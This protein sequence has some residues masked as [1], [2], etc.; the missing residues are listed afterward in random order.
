MI[1]LLLA[2]D[3]REPYLDKPQYDRTLDRLVRYCREEQDFRGHTGEK[4]WA[5]AAAHAADALDECAAS[6][7][8][9]PAACRMIWNGLSALMDG[10]RFVYQEEE[11]ERIATALWSMLSLE[12]VSVHDLMEWDRERISP[13]R[14]KQLERYRAINR[15]QVIRSLFMRLQDGEPFGDGKNLLEWER[16]Y[17]RFRRR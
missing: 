2:R 11:D 16:T 1:A 13:V 15:K 4:G 10:A 6:R 14:D 3:N 12:K 17:N 5:H 9:D 8:A 7:H